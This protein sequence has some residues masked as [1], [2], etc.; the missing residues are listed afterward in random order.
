[1]FVVVIVMVIVVIVYIGYSK[2]ESED[3]ATSSAVNRHEYDPLGA[4]TFG[5]ELDKTNMELLMEDDDIR[6]ECMEDFRDE[7]RDEFDDELDEEFDIEPDE[8]DSSD[9]ADYICDEADE[10]IYDESISDEFWI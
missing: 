8:V 4:N 9:P 7:F 5:D 3:A 6:E 10:T 1:M 2:S